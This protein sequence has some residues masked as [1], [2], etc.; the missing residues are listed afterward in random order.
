MYM[1]RVVYLFLVEA[2]L[3]CVCEFVYIYIYTYIYIYIY[4]HVSVCKRERESSCARARACL[5]LLVRALE[6]KQVLRGRL[7]CRLHG[8]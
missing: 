3:L 1:D 4:I 7:L 8:G 5:Q 2:R 6:P